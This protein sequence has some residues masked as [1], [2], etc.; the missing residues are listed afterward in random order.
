MKFAVLGIM[1]VLITGLLHI[2]FIMF[3]YGFNDSDRGA[4]VKLSEKMNNTLD[5]D[6]QQSTYEKATELQE[7]FGIGRFITLGLG[8][9]M[10]AVEVLNKPKLEA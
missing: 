10:F 6:T 2:M 7:F 1:L 3:D 4:F 9:V 5:S 8:L